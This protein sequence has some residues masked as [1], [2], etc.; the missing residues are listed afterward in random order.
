[1]QLVK[2]RIRSQAKGEEIELQSTVQW[3]HFSVSEVVTQMFQDLIKEEP[4]EYDIN[5]KVT[6]FQDIPEK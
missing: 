1:M 6:L 3:A 2:I 5:V 4:G